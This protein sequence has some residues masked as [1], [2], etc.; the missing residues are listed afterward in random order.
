ML[1]S[2][3][4]DAK[5]H[6][7]ATLLPGDTVG[8]A[9]RTFAERG[10]GAVVVQDLWQKMQ[11]VFSERDLVRLLARD[12]AAAL[13]RRLQEVLT[14]AV[15]TCRPADRI[16]VALAVMTANKVRHLP[17]IEAGRLA[18]IVSIG[19]LVKYR[20]DEKALEADVLLEIA[21]LRGAPPEVAERVPHA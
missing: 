12:G 18:G 16:E 4:L 21:R 10:I 15:I 11:G 19:D 1:I 6:A 3:V 9:V 13:G 8:H 17:V 14:R 2:H 7:V 5:G 20:L